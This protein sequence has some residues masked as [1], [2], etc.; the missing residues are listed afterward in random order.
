MIL[1]YDITAILKLT[2]LFVKHRLLG[3]QFLWIDIHQ[4]S[5]KNYITENRKI[6]LFKISLEYR[7][8][9]IRNA[10]FERRYIYIY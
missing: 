3:T 1:L 5:N 9:Y 8:T 2:D 4:T 7:Y 6:L 10:T